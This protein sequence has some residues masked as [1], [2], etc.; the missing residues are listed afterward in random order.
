[1]GLFWKRKKADEFVTL[2]LNEP[3][4]KPEQPVA[5][6]EQLADIDRTTKPT[7]E[8]TPFPPELIPP[9][10]GAGPAPVPVERE[11]RVAPVVIDKQVEQTREKPV[12]RGLRL[13][14]RARTQPFDGRVAGP[15]GG[16]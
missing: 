3:V 7:A 1:M 12:G 15:G 13:P 5:S 10:S 2:R 9:V 16:A 8:A 11:T 6:A 14:R 4:T